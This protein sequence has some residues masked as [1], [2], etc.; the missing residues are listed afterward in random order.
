MNNM[1]IGA[2]S[3]IYSREPEADRAFLCDVLGLSYVD[4]GEGWLIFELPTAE[5]AVHPS[6]KNDIHEFYFMC[7]DIQA[8]IAA[9]SEKGITCSP[10]QTTSWGKLTQISL[11]GGGNLGV[12]QPLHARP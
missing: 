3:I 10:I 4:A 7:R 11:P 1:I 12:Y 6:S 8:F 2:H 5:L 9:M